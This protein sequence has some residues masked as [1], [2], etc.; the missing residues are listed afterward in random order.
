MFCAV[1]GAK[2]VGRQGVLRS[3]SDMYTEQRSL[4]DPAFLAR[5]V[6]TTDVDHDSD[7]DVTPPLRFV[8]RN[9]ITSI[10]AGRSRQSPDGPRCRWQHGDAASRAADAGRRRR[11]PG[12]GTENA[13]PGR[14]PGSA[15]RRS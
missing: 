10:D 3:T 5:Q 15:M 9:R 8:T 13:P 2:P 11:P 14:Q 1:T 6:G 4:P 7:E 12:A